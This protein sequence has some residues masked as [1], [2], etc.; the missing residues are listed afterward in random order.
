MIFSTTVVILA[1]YLVNS[2]LATKWTG[3]DVPD[4]EK[5]YK[6]CGFEKPVD[7]CDP[8]GMWSVEEHEKDLMD[9]QNGLWYWE[10]S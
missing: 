7:V 5:D 1:G 9:M 4:P 10:K 3:Y 8:D 6:A 2:I